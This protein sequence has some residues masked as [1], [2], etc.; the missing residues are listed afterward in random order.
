MKRIDYLGNLNIDGRIVGL[1]K[2]TLRKRIQWRE[3]D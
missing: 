2:G 3:L 1:F